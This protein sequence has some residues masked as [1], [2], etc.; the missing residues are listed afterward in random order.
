VRYFG[1]EKEERAQANI[2]AGAEEQHERGRA[3]VVQDNLDAGKAVSL[4]PQQSKHGF[5][6]RPNC[7][8]EFTNCIEH[9]LVLPFGKSLANVSICDR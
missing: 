3:R 5:G 4:P 1:S 2:A 9:E 8:I 7:D 6:K